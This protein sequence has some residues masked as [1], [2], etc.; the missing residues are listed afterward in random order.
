M[1]TT[2][3]PPNRHAN[4]STTAVARASR[5]RRRRTRERVRGMSEGAKRPSESAGEGVA[6][7]GARLSQRRLS[8]TITT[9]VR[10]RIGSGG[11]GEVVSGCRA[12]VSVTRSPTTYRIGPGGCGYKLCPEATQSS[13]SHDHHTRTG[14]AGGGRPE[15]SRDVVDATRE[16]TQTRI[17]IATYDLRAARDPDLHVHETRR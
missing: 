13:R 10:E 17:D 15:P 7:T 8:H 16:S 1:D 3:R 14:S 2:S 9:H 11:R 6:V 4:P 12:V 5:G